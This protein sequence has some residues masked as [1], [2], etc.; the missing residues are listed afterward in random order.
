[1]SPVVRA[2]DFQYKNGMVQLQFNHNLSQMD[3][4]VSN[5]R[6]LSYNWFCAVFL[7]D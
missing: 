1:M 5:M 6:F 2:Y 7:I 3:S 4:L